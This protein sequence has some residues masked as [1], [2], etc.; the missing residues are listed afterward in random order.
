MKTFI[1]FLI[2]FALISGLDEGRQRKEDE[3]YLPEDWDWDNLP[4]NLTI[5]P[6]EDPEGETP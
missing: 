6:M 1:L 3:Q 2:L 5:L 4:K